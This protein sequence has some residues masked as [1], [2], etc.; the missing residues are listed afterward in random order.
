MAAASARS[1]IF[2]AGECARKF[3]S[4]T[5]PW[6][7]R[8]RSHAAAPPPRVASHHAC[9]LLHVLLCPTPHRVRSPAGFLCRR[10]CAQDF[11]QTNGAVDASSALACRSSTARVAARHACVLLRAL[12]CPT[13]H[14]RPRSRLIPFSACLHSA[15]AEVDQPTGTTRPLGTSRSS[16]PSARTTSAAAAPPPHGHAAPLDRRHRRHALRAL[17]P[18]RHKLLH[19]VLL[20]LCVLRAH[21][22]A[23]R[24]ALRRAWVYA[25]AHGVSRRVVRL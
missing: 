23:D 22:R 1:Q 9:V 6:T 12:L 2:C 25:Y 8:V 19:D 7:H 18:R 14:R 24:V 13:P 20:R 11:C 15:N 5:A 4:L 10:L 3:F 16:A 17:P 21:A